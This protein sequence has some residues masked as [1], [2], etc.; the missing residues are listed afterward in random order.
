MCN[1]CTVIMRRQFP[2][3]KPP[4]RRKREREKV[5]RAYK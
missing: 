1:K 4:F 5:V 2:R 3:W